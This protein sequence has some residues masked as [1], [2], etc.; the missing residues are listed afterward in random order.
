LKRSLWPV[1][2]L[3]RQPPHASLRERVPDRPRPMSAGEQLSAQREALA[4]E[5]LRRHGR[6]RLLVHGESM[7][8]TLWP[9]DVAEIEDCSLPDVHRGDMVLAFR[10]GR[11]FLHR[12]LSQSQRQIFQTGGDSMPGPDPAFSSEAFLGRLI[13]VTRTGET[14]FPPTPMTPWTRALGVVFCYCGPARRLALRL[15]ARRRITHADGHASDLC[16]GETR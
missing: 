6:L 14:P 5:A 11:F 4:V 16:H 3:A 9:G 15:H 13:R 1:G 8:P 7:L 10:D 12:L 2:R